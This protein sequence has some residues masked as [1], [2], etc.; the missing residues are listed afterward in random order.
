MLI[1]VFPD[2]QVLAFAALITCF[3]CSLDIF[4]ASEEKKNTDDVQ[5]SLLLMSD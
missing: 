3:Y 5:L 2:F 1:L 4:L